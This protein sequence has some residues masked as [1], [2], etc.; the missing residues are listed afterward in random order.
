MTSAVTFFMCLLDLR[1]CRL[2]ILPQRHGCSFDP[3]ASTTGK[4]RSR[5]GPMDKK[6]LAGMDV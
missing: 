1:P 4:A 5:L 2:S 6:Q 3:L